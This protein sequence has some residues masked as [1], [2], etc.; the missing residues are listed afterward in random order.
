MCIRDRGKILRPGLWTPGAPP[1]VQPNAA[2]EKS[3]AD[4]YGENSQN[5]A[6]RAPPS[7]IHLGA[8]YR[9]GAGVAAERRSALVT[10][11]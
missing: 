6:E 11:M 5:D 3:D 10:G 9:I 2:L 1:V 8:I 7:L 4:G